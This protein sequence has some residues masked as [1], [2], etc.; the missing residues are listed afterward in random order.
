MQIISNG[1]R[2]LAISGNHTIEWYKGSHTANV[3]GNG[4][5]DCFTFAWAK[6]RPSMLDFTTSLQTY[7][8][9]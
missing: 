6:D 2:M 3:H 4:W 5:T 8:E 9:N 1:E 7:L